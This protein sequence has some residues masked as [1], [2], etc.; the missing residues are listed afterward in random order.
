VYTSN[1]TYPTRRIQ[2]DVSNATYPTRR[3]QR[4]VSNAT[5]RSTDS[6]ATPPTLP[7]AYA[8]IGHPM[9]RA[10][11][12]RAELDSSELSGVK[13]SRR[14]PQT[15][16]RAQRP[17]VGSRRPDATPS[18]RPT[19]DVPATSPPARRRQDIIPRPQDHNLLNISHERLALWGILRESNIDKTRRFPCPLTTSM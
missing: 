11:W 1:A 2:R 3:I 9:K 10:P 6:M 7:S 18:P 14:V 5:E 13:R 4:D 16:R 17:N 19:R 8:T 12:G 15:F